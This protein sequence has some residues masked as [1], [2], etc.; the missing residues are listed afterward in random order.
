M[1]MCSVEGLEST[2][3][4]VTDYIERIK[5]NMQDYFFR[6]PEKGKARLQVVQES[7]SWR[8][9]IVVNSSRELNVCC[10]WDLGATYYA[11]VSLPTEC[12]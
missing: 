3:V 10:S 7:S 11:E 5:E 12:G 8:K 1:F 4:N 6:V 2:G 9:L